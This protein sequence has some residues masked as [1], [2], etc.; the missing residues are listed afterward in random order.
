MDSNDS[1]NASDLEGS[2]NLACHYEMFYQYPPELDSV[3]EEIGL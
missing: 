2:C 3:Y 1:R